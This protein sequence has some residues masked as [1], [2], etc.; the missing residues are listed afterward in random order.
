MNSFAKQTSSARKIHTTDEQGAYLHAEIDDFVMIKL[1]GRI[2]DILSKMIPEY[3]KFVVYKN[4]T[5]TLYM[6]LMKA[7]YGCI[8]SA[9]LW[10]ELFT[11]EL[12]EMG[13]NLNPYD[14]CVANNMI[15]GKQC[16]I[17]WWVDDNC[18][19][20]LSAKLL[21]RI[22]KRIKMKFEKNDSNQR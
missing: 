21:D 14:K 16:T 11:G 17:A 7:L 13:F 1:Q 3:K 20:H 4:S 22:I 6:Q 18:L 12:R 9:L 10:Y 19:T 15:D 8:K 2:M 5:V